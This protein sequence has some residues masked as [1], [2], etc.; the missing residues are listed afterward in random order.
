MHIHNTNIEHSF[1]AASHNDRHSPKAP[2]RL[3]SVGMELIV[4]YVMTAVPE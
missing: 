4:Q 3:S 1:T 2:I